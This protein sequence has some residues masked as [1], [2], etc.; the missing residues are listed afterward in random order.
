MKA[1]LKL[2]QKDVDYINAVWK[3]FKTARKD[4]MHIAIEES[5][6]DK[7]WKVVELKK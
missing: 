2:T 6:K 4:K 3:D 5:I 7:E 1:A